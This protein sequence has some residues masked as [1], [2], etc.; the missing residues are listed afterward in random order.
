MPVRGGMWWSV[1]EIGQDR[2]AEE[3]GD[4]ECVQEKR[5]FSFEIVAEL[6]GKGHG[7]NQ[8]ELCHGH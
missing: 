3:Q 6:G 4:G 5:D 7:G 1:R 2:A 8:R